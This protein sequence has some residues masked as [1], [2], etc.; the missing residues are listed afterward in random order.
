MRACQSPFDE[1]PA[2][3]PPPKWRSRPT[4]IGPVTAVAKLQ[5]GP[6][7]KPNAGKANGVFQSAPACERATGKFAGMQHGGTV[8]AFGG[9]GPQ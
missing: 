6:A 8:P 7:G 3:S 9:K 4:R 5:A 1:R 2:K